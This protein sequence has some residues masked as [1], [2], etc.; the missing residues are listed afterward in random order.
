LVFQLASNRFSNGISFGFKISI[1]VKVSIGT[2][3]F[4][5]YFKKGKTISKT[6]LKAKRRI[7][8]GGAF[9]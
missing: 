9:N 3:S 1:S 4:G 2:I 7:S 6:L 8:S 5:I